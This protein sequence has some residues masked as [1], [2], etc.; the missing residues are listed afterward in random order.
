MADGMTEFNR[1][2]ID[3]FRR[4][5]GKVGGQFA[6]APLILVTHKGA[7]SG[8]T[9]TTPLVYSKDGERY[10]VIASKAGSP[11]NPSWYHNLVAH[12]EVTLEVADQKFEARATEVTGAE[13]D[14]LFTAQATLMPVFNEYQKRTTRK[15]PVIALERLR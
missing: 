5:G 2:L 11:S 14:K 12:P 9:Y 10:V 13:R 6:G 7:K 1:N 3:E 8:K 15:I 4:N